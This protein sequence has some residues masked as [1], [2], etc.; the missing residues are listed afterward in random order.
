[1][2]IG[3]IFFASTTLTDEPLSTKDQIAK[4]SASLGKFKSCRE[5]VPE[6]MSFAI[7][8]IRSLER[9]LLLCS[10]R[11]F[12]VRRGPVHM[13]VLLADEHE[14][15]GV[16][17]GILLHLQEDLARDL[18]PRVDGGLV[19]LD[20]EGARAAG[21]AHFATTGIIWL[22]HPLLHAANIVLPTGRLPSESSA[23]RK[24]R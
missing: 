13:R 12:C 19:E 16:G 4:S 9:G 8:A 24:S 2:D 3:N 11:C 14:L 7:D 23:S 22:S 15:K 20:A 21:V 17:L 5:R 18:A 6:L 10:L 1:M